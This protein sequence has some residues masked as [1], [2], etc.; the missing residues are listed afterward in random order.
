MWPPGSLKLTVRMSHGLSIRPFTRVTQRY[1]GRIGPRE[2]D[3]MNALTADAVI[4]VAIL[5]LWILGV[6]FTFWLLWRA[7][8]GR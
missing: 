7:G 8:K 1:Y 5:S 3:R 4:P 2:G 6:V